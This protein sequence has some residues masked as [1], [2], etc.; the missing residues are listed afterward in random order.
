MKGP[1]PYLLLRFRA[2]FLGLLTLHVAIFKS[3]GGTSGTEGLFAR[4]DAATRHSW[5]SQPVRIHLNSP[6]GRGARATRTVGLDDQHV[7]EEIM[8]APNG[9]CAKS[10]AYVKSGAVLRHF[11]SHQELGSILYN[12]C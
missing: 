3:L 1:F 11:V 2:G 6:L 9:D 10:L 7:V 12:L 5:V 4:A 8:F